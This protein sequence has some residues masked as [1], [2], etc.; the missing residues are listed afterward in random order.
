MAMASRGDGGGGGQKRGEKKDTPGAR[1]KR[2]GADTA[3]SPARAAIS[4]M[5]SVRRGCV[6]RAGRSCARPRR[7]AA[8]A[9]VRTSLTPRCVAGTGGTAARRPQSHA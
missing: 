3:A 6:A 5:G 7:C 9:V 8:L 2:A 4:H 1:T